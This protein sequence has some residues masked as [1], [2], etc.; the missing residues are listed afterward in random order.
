MKEEKH[1]NCP[2]WQGVLR[3]LRNLFKFIFVHIYISYRSNILRE[4]AVVYI[5]TN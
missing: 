3:L 4:G 5:H 1:V 2:N